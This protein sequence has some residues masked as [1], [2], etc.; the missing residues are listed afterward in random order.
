MNEQILTLNTINRLN[1]RIMRLISTLQHL[2]ISKNDNSASLLKNDN[3]SK[4]RN[5]C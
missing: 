2:G 4:N 1:N 5:I 3:S